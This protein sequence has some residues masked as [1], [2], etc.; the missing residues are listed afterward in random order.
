MRYLEDP[1]A[2]TECLLR[3]CVISRA[4]TH[5]RGCGGSS[6]IPTG[7]L[8]SSCESNLSCNLRLS[9]PKLIIYGRQTEILNLIYE[10]L[11]LTRFVLI[12]LDFINLYFNSLQI[13]LLKMKLCP[14]NGRSPPPCPPRVSLRYGYLKGL[15]SSFLECLRPLLLYDTVV[16]TFALPSL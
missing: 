2:L 3:H 1:K 9:L 12:L 11:M 8:C 10:M 7:L 6:Y 4:H 13:V 16:I 15:K 14:H 5:W